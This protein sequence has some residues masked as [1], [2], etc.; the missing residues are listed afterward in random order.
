MLYGRLARMRAGLPAAEMGRTAE[1]VSVWVGA[2]TKLR[3]EDPTFREAYEKLDRS[4]RRLL[5]GVAGQ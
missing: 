5:E 2:G 1:Q 4:L 3:L